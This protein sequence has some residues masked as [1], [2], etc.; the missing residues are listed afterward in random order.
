MPVDQPRRTDALTGLNVE[1]KGFVA[2]D[3]K[4]QTPL[5]GMMNFLARA[6]FGL[7]AV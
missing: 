7:L 2:A 4:E 6:I 3:K 1:Q 5:D